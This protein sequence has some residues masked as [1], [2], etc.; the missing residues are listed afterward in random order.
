MIE[1]AREYWLFIAAFIL[2]GI[3]YFGAVREA[4]KRI[5]HGKRKG[6]TSW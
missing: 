6:E 2:V 1:S 5:I 3:A 4:I